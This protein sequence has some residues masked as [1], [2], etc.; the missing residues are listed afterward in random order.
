MGFACLYASIMQRIL[1]MPTYTDGDKLHL[2][3]LRSDC[4][5]CT[6]QKYCTVAMRLK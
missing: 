2:Q 4:I 1:N 5:L 3:W 6:A